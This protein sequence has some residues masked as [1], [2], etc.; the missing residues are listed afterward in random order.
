MF[1]LQSF[2]SKLQAAVD[3]YVAWWWKRKKLLKKASNQIKEYLEDVFWPYIWKEISVDTHTGKIEGIL[4]WIIDDGGIVGP[5]LR[6][7]KQKKWENLPSTEI[8]W[9]QLLQYWYKLKIREAKI[10]DSTLEIQ[11]S[12]Q[13]QVAELVH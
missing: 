4:T 12:V 5:F 7:K 3:I 9:V 10:S 13:E 1:E 8:I 6:V 2:N 11:D